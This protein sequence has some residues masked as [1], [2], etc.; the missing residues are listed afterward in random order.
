MITTIMIIVLFWAIGHKD[1]AILCSYQRLGTEK[2]FAIPVV[3]L[4]RCPSGMCVGGGGS[5][6]FCLTEA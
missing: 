5:F 3:G 4:T 1:D 6:G 2:D